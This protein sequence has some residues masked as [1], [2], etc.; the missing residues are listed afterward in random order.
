MMELFKL[1]HEEN[2]NLTIN[3]M[4]VSCG[5]WQRKRSFRVRFS[6]KA[7][8]ISWTG[9]WSPK[10]VMSTK[11]LPFSH[12][13]IS[14]DRRS[15]RLKSTDK[16]IACCKLL[17]L[18]KTGLVPY[19][20]CWYTLLVYQQCTMQFHGVNWTILFMNQLWNRTN[21]D[22]PTGVLRQAR[23]KTSLSAGPGLWQGEQVQ[24]NWRNLQPSWR[25]SAVSPGQCWHNIPTSSATGLLW[26]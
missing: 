17:K 25:P 13:P 19:R 9:N 2:E 26:W 20:V 7:S 16:P 12:W 6:G 11:I 4:L 24:N 5:S 22:R 18:F 8:R 10:G 21:I 15:N 3:I 1:S 14:I 23:R